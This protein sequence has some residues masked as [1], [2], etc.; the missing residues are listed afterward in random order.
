MT[1]DNNQSGSESISALNYS[2]HAIDDLRA[3]LK[4]FPA[5]FVQ[6][7]RAVHAMIGL[8]EKS[9]KFVLPN[10]GAL[11]DIEHFSQAH[12]DLLKLPYP[13]VAFEIPW[14]TEH[15]IKNIGG[16]AQ[17][18]SSRRIALCWE[19]EATPAELSALNTI[20]QK[21]PEG[22]VF[23]LPIAWMDNVG[24]W[25]IGVG[26]TFIPY[27]NTFAAIEEGNAV[28]PLTARSMEGLRAAGLLGKKP[29]RF[30]AE[31]FVL[32]Y[33]HF[34]A[35]SRGD[36]EAGFMS[37][38]S[39]T[40]D[41]AQALLQACAVLNCENVETADILPSPK[42]NKAREAKGK[43]PFFSYKYLVLAPER[44]ASGRAD[45]G[46][47]HSSP[48]MHL[49]RGHLR[50]LENKTVWVRAAMVGTSNQHGIV[51]KHYVLKPGKQETAL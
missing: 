30:D 2:A 12:V 10:C 41:E 42:L 11:L 23:V 13:V 50:R 34:E 22:G 33:E 3:A 40:R 31:P 9:V 43:Q 4:Q 25:S 6:S 45:G 14:K 29:R 1:A 16:M 27:D 35:V 37:I 15:E 19:P 32:Q 51:D 7:K 36:T 17:Y 5:H 44:S 46:G 39:D 18:T 26:G 38:M 21:A 49:R 28:N 48:R 8:L 47:T 24:M 20:L